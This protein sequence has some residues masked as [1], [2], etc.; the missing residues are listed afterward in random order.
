M[1]AAGWLLNLGFAGGTSAE[2]VVG[3][4]PRRRR[5]MAAIIHRRRARPK[6]GTRSRKK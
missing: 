4:A 3:G 6:C 1:A 2:P 5:S